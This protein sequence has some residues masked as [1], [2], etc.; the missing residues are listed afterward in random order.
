MSKINIIQCTPYFPPHTGGLETVAEQIWYYWKSENFWEVIQLTTSCKQEEA[1]KK[2]E[3]IQ[4]KWWIIWYK[5]SD[6]EH[7]IIPSFE[8]IS[9]FPVYNFF[10]PKTYII[11][12]YLRQY[13]K[14]HWEVRLITHT[15]FFLSTFFWGVLA[16]IQQIPFFHIEHW[17][18][19][20][21]LWSSFKTKIGI[22]YDKTL[23]KWSVKHADWVL[24]ISK[25][26]KKFITESFVNRKVEV[27]YRWLDIPH[28]KVQKWWKIKIIFIGRLV[29]LKWVSDLIQ[30]YKMW[31][32]L[33]ELVIIWDG[34]ERKK[35]EKI[36]QGYNV[37]FL[38]NKDQDFVIRYLQS[39]K[40]I[41]VNP[42]LQE[43]LPTTVIEALMTKNVVVASDVWG[44]SEIS[45][46]S[47]L[48]LFPA[49]NIAILTAHIIQAQKNYDIF[50][51]QSFEH[52]TYKFS[53]KTNIYKLYEY[54]K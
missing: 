40:C 10:H 13:I 29:S 8:L 37:T 47:D 39:H 46:F 5:K 31:E 43:W 19:H 23:W 25:A 45:S 42:S 50:A 34:V 14:N 54:I 44:T 49:W 16:K 41:L 32:N 30:S 52:V 4:Y 3:N 24:A 6:I 53:W 7:I 9:N 2:Y 21:K 51:W 20:A 38:G 33:W 1:L 27:L 12:F 18:W 48:L 26:C 17:S 36:S 28:F 35:L 11:Y 15:R 22:I